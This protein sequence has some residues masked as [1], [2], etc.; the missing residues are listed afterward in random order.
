MNDTLS[1]N[2][3]F[4]NFSVAGQVAVVTGAS[5]GI[6]KGI[7]LAL[8]RAG[9]SVVC[10]SRTEADVVAAAKQIS[11]ATGNPTLGIACDISSSEQ[12]TMLLQRTM[13]ELGR[14]DILVNNA[15][16]AGPNDPV[17]T[18][19]EAFSKTLDWNVTPAFD[20]SKQ[21][22]EL[23]LESGTGSIINISS[24]AAQLRQKNFSAYGSA[25]AALSHLTRLLAQDFAPNVRV[26]AIEPG[27]ILTDALE[28]FLTP[29]MKS[30]MIKTTPLGRLGEVDDVANSALFLASP[31]SAWITGKIIELDGG[32]EAPL[33]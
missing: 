19:A 27:A 12:R 20:L 18:S 11:A 1:Q 22:Y 23:M 7:A 8:S 33:W 15:G 26:N 4:E 28:G 6:G 21:A 29:E 10:A 2:S 5:K 3:V 24:R 14:I 31:A 16:G 30:A 32:V 13:N 25:K 9:A 17:K